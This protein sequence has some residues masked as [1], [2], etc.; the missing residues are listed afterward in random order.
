VKLICLG[1]VSEL[2]DN[3]QS[4][5]WYKKKY[6]NINLKEWICLKIYIYI[7]WNNNRYIIYFIL[8]KW[9]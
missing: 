9:N 3:M 4:E 2:F 5:K 7:E 1:M 6:N 8:F